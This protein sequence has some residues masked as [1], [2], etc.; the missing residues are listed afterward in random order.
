MKDEI[1]FRDYWKVLVRRRLSIIGI[2]CTAAIV[3]TIFVLLQPNVYRSKATIMLLGKS[4]SGLQ[5]ALGELSGLLPL[6]LATS[7]QTS[8]ERIVAILDSRTLVEAVIQEMDLIPKLF[9][10]EWDAEKQQ[11]KTDDPPTVQGAV[12]ALKSLVA[13]SSDKKTGVITIAI[14]HTDPELAAAI[15][16]QYIDALQRILNENAFSLAKKNRLFIESQLQKTQK[17]LAAAEE[18]LKQF[19]QTHKIIALEAQVEAAVEA[20]ASLQSEIMAKEVQLGV[21]R[22]AVTGASR[23]VALL[24][25]ELKGL[26]SQL[27]RLQRR[28]PGSQISP[29]ARSI[30]PFEEAP[31]IKLQYVRLKREAIIQDK[32][33]ALFTQQLEQAKIDESRD[34]T[35]FQVLDR[36]VTPEKRIKPNRRVSVMLSTLIGVFLGVLVA[37]FRDY[38]D[39]TVQTREQIER[40][41]G[42][43]LLATVSTS[44]RQTR[45]RKV[46]DAR[47]PVPESDLVLRHPSQVTA[48]EAYRYLHTRLRH[49][50]RT[51]DV[52]AV[53]FVGAAAHDDAPAVLANLAIVAAG[54]GEKTL[55]IDGD[56]RHPVLQR[57]FNCPVIPGLT[58]VLSDPDEWHKG[59]QTTAVDNLYL[60]PA[61]TKS[62]TTLSLFE[63]SDFY[64]LFARFKENYDLIL[65]TA[66]PVSAFADAVLLSYRVDA[67]CLVITRGVTHIESIKEAK[68]SLEAIQINVVGAVLNLL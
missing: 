13:I 60:L 61:G 50:H 54:A 47:P 25:E 2:A 57:F 27:V 18:A 24:Q 14:E 42:L 34:E 15:A 26:R 21:L 36:A 37:F 45:R 28:T 6:N 58:E 63:T 20:V 40:Q 46:W 12:K 39:A 7:S 5:G 8:S 44:I 62:T 19:E 16:N 22:R 68:E 30:P 64:A 1:N 51:S 4:H 53:L 41:V 52:Q 23:E 10:E 56:I 33:F 35:A 65:C 9:V 43:P 67:T 17:D 66:P 55:L 49:L 38:L 29:D 32:L 59:I 11:W 3:T 48:V 31:E